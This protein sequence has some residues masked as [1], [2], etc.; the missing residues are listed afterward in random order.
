[1]NTPDPRLIAHACGRRL[2]KLVESK[3][4]SSYQMSAL[5]ELFGELAVQPGTSPETLRG[6][7]ELV[8]AR[9]SDGEA[10]HGLTDE[11]VR[12]LWRGYY[13]AQLSE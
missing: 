6:L 4:W 7:I 10:L 8:G 9:G 5:R 3:D 2:R 1:M 12:A 11:H 13:G